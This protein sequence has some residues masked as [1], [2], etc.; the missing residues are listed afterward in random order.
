MSQ[1]ALI[2]Q[3]P[4]QAAAQLILLFHGVGSNARSMGPLGQQLA[5]RFPQAMVVS[6]NSPYPS[7]APGGFQWFSVAGITEENRHDRIAEAMPAFIDCIQHWQAKAGLGPEATALIGFSQ[8]AIMALESTQVTPA[9]ASRVVAISGRFAQLPAQSTYPGTIHFLHGKQDA[10]I[11]YSH[12]VM[13]AHHL[14]DLDTDITAEVLP[15]IGHEVHPEFV[16]LILDKLGT[17]ISHRVWADALKPE[18][19]K[20]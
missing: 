13:A 16:P 9:L 4:A 8:G 6:V 19:T 1:D 20:H 11:P 18:P 14:R 17:H 12:T 10:V 2:L 5:E 7:H 15:F 3:N